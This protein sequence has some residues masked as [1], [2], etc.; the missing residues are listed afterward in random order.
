DPLDHRSVLQGG[1]LRSERPAGLDEG[2]ADRAAGDGDPRRPGAVLLV[3]DPAVAPRWAGERRRRAGD[4]VLDDVVP[5]STVELL[6]AMVHLQLVAGQ[7]RL[8]GQRHPGVD[9]LRGAGPE[10]PAADADHARDLRAGV[11]DRD[12]ARRFLDAQG[13]GA[14]AADRQVRAG[15]DVLGDDGRVRLR[16]RGPAVPP[17]RRVVLPGRW[18][19]AV[20]VHLPPAAAARDHRDLLDD[21]GRRV[22]ALLRQRPRR[23]VLRAWDRTGQ[24][25]GGET[26]GAPVAGGDVLLP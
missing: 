15:D 11:R 19:G 25:A 13:Q 9:V 23:A 17:A 8:V 12:H 6:P 24:G 2:G 1:A 7:R 14:V 21:G 5:G 18:L 3:P 16:L 26:T 4:R 22:S 20:L 10:H